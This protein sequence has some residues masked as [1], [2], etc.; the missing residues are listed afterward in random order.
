M[1]RQRTSTIGRLKPGK[2]EQLGSRGACLF[3]NRLGIGDHPVLGLWGGSC[4]AGV[5]NH[6]QPT[7]NNQPLKRKKAIEGVIN[8]DVKRI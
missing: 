5:F 8:R 7:K 6:L 2:G 1:G 3:K 4:G